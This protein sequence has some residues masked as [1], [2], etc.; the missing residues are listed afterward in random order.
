MFLPGQL[1]SGQSSSPRLEWSGMAQALRLLIVDD[2]PESL[3]GLAGHLADRGHQVEVLT[4][5]MEAL[6]RF[7]RAQHYPF[8]LAFID[9]NL[10]GLDGPGLVRELRRRGDQTPVAFITGYHSVAARLRG[11][12]AT[13]RVSGLITKPPP[14]A[15]IERLLEHA[16]RAQ[17][18]S[19][20]ERRA[21]DFGLGSGGH[22]NLATGSGGHRTLTSR[23]QLGQGTG[24]GSGGHAQIGKGSGLPVDDDIPYYGSTRSIRPPKTADSEPTAGV[25]SRVTRPSTNPEIIPDH[26]ISGHTPISLTPLGQPATNAKNRP[27]QRTPLPMEPV[28]QPLIQRQRTPNPSGFFPA[29]EAPATGPVIRARDPV[30]GNYRDPSGFFPPDLMAPHAREAPGHPLTDPD[31]S[32]PRRPAAPTAPTTPPPQLPSTTSRFRRSVGSAPPPPAAPGSPI[33]SRIRR[34]ITGTHGNPA[35][36]PASD[37]PS[38]VVA[39]A[40]CHGQFTV[41]I[42]PQAYT[43][44][45]VHCGQ[46]NRI[47]PV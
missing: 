22:Q 4:D 13:L 43:V 1:A 32:R 37:A 44:L 9:V 40:H 6:A 27:P 10:T 19:L 46:L 33:T 18:S 24:L 39:C 31:A 35:A 47:D 17:R 8:H 29:T 5:P 12:L 41:L 38:C 26:L 20:Q 7:Q 28:A 21:S 11:D 2:Q 36:V 15:E 23:Q 16:D 3:A 45:C 25:L 42:K 30:T 34:G 14:M